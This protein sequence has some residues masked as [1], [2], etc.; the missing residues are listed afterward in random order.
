MDNESVASAPLI[1][2]LGTEAKSVGTQRL[3][4]VPVLPGTASFELRAESFTLDIQVTVDLNSYPYNVLNGFLR[5]NICTDAGKQWIVISGAFSEFFL[6]MVAVQQPLPSPPIAIELATK[7]PGE[8][9]QQLAIYGTKYQTPDS[10]PGTYA[11]GAGFP[12]YTY[13]TTLFKG[14]QP[15]PS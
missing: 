1:G 5:G 10:W 12:S 8:C 3:V 9:Y 6:G 14:W 7:S 4:G 11:F 2:T 15:L 13:Q